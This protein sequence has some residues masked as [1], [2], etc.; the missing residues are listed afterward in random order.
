MNVAGKSDVRELVGRGQE[1][2]RLLAL[3]D[4]A[5]SGRGRA[6]L[7]LG[8]AGIGKTRLAEAFAAASA[9]AGSRVA[10]GRCTE[11]ESPAYWPWRQLLRALRGTTSLGVTHDGPGGR[12]VLFAT[13]ANELEQAAAVGPMLLVVDDIHW[14]DP[15]SLAL[16]RFVVSVL[17][18]LPAVLVLTARDDPLEL[19]TAAADLLRDLPPAVQRILLGGLDRHSTHALVQGLW[20][21]SPTP[22]AFVTE[23]HQRTKGNPFFVQEVTNLRLLQGERSGFAV[24]PGVGQVVGRRLA[25]LSQAA[26]ALLEVSS[27][28]DDEIDAELLALITG[29]SPQD[30]VRLLDEAE[31]ARLLMRTDQALNFAHPLIREALYEA[32]S[33]ATRSELHA[34]VADAFADYAARREL[35]IDGLDGRLAAHWRQASGEH[36]RRR[37]GQ[38]ALAAARSAVRRMGYEQAA[39]YCRWALDAGAGDRLGTMLELGEAL[40]LAGE[41]TQ[42]RAL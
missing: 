35:P 6:A 9:N 25:R 13:V 31:R 11:A 8:E 23:V 27:V 22:A 20:G 1:F 33:H 17:P 18:D 21:L 29:R 4:D 41:P 3:L 42:S 40:V 14:A 15:S 19:S 36:A 24:P 32:Q 16:L 5:R 7:V 10:W 26:H 12:D 37:A 38:H 39:R 2:E 28:I 34:Q 30:V